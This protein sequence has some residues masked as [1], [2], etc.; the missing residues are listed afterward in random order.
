M[1]MVMVVVIMMMMSLSHG[2]EV[3]GLG[4]RIQHLGSIAERLMV[5]SQIGFK[6]SILLS[7]PSK[8]WGNKYHTSA[9]FSC[10]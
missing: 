2:Q 3:A 5:Y 10:F 1:V 7:Q 8:C 6:L 9:A 4:P